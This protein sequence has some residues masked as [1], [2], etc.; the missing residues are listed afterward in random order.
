VLGP[1]T[2]R[3]RVPMLGY[4]TIS[5]YNYVPSFIPITRDIRD[6]NCNVQFYDYLMEKY[7]VLVT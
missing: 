5:Y 7:V 2:L 4:V 6:L 3:Y 1:I